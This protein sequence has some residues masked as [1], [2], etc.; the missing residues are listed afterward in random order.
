MNLSE[1]MSDKYSYSQC[2]KEEEEANKFS[3]DILIS[4][5]DWKY[6]VSRGNFSI[7]AIKRFAEYIKIPVDIIIG[8][9]QKD[10][11]I[12]YAQHVK[13]QQKV[14]TLGFEI[15]QISLAVEPDIE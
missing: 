12:H 13:Y 1:S 5:A 7:E 9:L 3:R 14:Q 8:R 4:P 10:K 11:I 2:D 6:F 15:P